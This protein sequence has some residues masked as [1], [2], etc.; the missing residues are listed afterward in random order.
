MFSCIT[1]G[2]LIS[3]ASI[4]YANCPNKII[5]SFLFSL[6]LISIIRIGLKLFTSMV[7]TCRARI[8]DIYTI[9]FIFVGNVIG[10][11]FS[12][13]SPN[14]SSEI[15]M[16]KLS[17]SAWHILFG[18]ILCG[19]FIYLT[20]LLDF[21]GRNMLATIMCVMAFMLGGGEHSI[22]DICFIFNARY[23]TWEALLFIVLVIIGN[24]F[25]AKL[26]RLLLEACV[27]EVKS[28]G[29][30]VQKETSDN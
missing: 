19:F 15:V 16:T 13:L 4:T 7:G 11:C 30:T 10:S 2:V 5:G 3:L 14:V 25:G 9:V 27:D 26:C 18:G 20:V 21:D 8:A 24:V 23:F 17:Q 1:A 29:K 12:F 6:A 22:A 28:N